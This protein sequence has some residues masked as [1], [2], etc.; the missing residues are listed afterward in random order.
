[1]Q[2]FQA[3]QRAG[4]KSRGDYMKWE[5]DEEVRHALEA[6]A[7]ANRLEKIYDREG[8]M[9]IVEDAIEVA[10][11]QGDARTM[12]AGAQE[13]NKMQGHYAPEKR[14]VKLEIEHEL[15]VKQIQEMDE[16]ELL[17]ALDKE[18]PYIDAEFEELPDEK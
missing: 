1:M 6:H 13:F 8:V 18:Q 11:T 5:K 10:K 7:A 17:E 12:I 9:R 4:Y 3:A 16:H 14:E 15:R 2:P